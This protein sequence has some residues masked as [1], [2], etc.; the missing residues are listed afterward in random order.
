MEEPLR[1]LCAF[2]KG[3]DTLVQYAACSLNSVF[4]SYGG[5]R[6]GD[7]AQF[8]SDYSGGDGA[9]TFFSSEVSLLFKLLFALLVMLVMYEDIANSWVYGM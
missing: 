8:D 9:S 4:C 5:R 7:K 6:R 2:Q 1:R 3:C